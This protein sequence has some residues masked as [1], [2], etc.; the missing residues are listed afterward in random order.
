M[1]WCLFD[2][3]RALIVPFPF[4]NH[5]QHGG[6][7]LAYVTGFDEFFP[8]G[9]KFVELQKKIQIRFD[10]ALEIRFGS[11][12]SIC[13]AFSGYWVQFCSCFVKGSGR[14]L[15]RVQDLSVSP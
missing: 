4:G 3:E 10:S 9:S 13:N 5:G 11:V 8:S 12:L 15:K 2:C 7:L 14:K 1:N 6:D